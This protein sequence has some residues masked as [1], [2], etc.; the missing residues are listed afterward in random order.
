MVSIDRVYQTV[1]RILNKEQ[2]GYLPPV[3]FNLF[4]NMAQTEIFEQYFYDLEQFMRIPMT[5]SNYADIVNNINEKIEI[6]ER[7][8]TIDPSTPQ[9]GSLPEI[10]LYPA[11]FYRLG[12]VTISDTG[13][14]ADEVSHKKIP[15]ITASPL[16]YPTLTQPVF[17]RHAGGI[18]L[19]PQLAGVAINMVYVGEPREVYW[20]YVNV[21]GKANYN[22]NTSADFELHAS[23]LPELV[24]KI[25]ALAGVAIRAADVA[26]FAQA[27]EASMIQ[28]EKA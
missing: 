25:C 3:E 24:V 28:Q 5:D 26:Q 19:Y 14:I 6:L 27:D 23:E 21:Q 16:T 4:A 15:F 2:R 12:V 11:D 17:V 20:G 1:Q 10:F 8:E 9:I 13:I 7:T 18:A 22:A